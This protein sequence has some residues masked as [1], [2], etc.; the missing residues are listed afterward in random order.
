M[1][2]GFLG[3]VVLMLLHGPIYAKDRTGGVSGDVIDEQGKALESVNVVLLKTA[4]NTLVKASLTDNKGIFRIES[5]DAGRYVLKATLIGFQTFTDTI[6]IEGTVRKLPS[7]R[8]SKKSAALDEVTVRTQKPFMEVK[9]DKI[10]VNVENSIVS[11]G[12]TVMEVLQRSP[13]ITVDQN[14]RISMK[15]KQ[16]VTIMMDGK[17]VPVAGDNLA[18]LLKNMPSSTVEKIELI[19]N[20]GAKYDAAGTGGIINI[21]TKKDKRMGFNGSAT[22]SFGQGVY[23]RTNDALNLNYKSKKI[24][25]YVNYGFVTRTGFNG[26]ILDRKFLDPQTGKVDTEYKQANNLLLPMRYHNIMAGVDYNLSSKTTLGVA[27]TGTRTRYEPSGTSFSDVYDRNGVKQSEFITVNDSKNRLNDYSFNLNFKHDFDTSGTE[28]TADADYATYRYNTNQHFINAFFDTTDAPTRQNYD[29]LGSPT[30]ATTIR[31]FKTDFTHP[32]K[33]SMRFEA[34][35]KLSYVTAGDNSQYSIKDTITDVYKYDSSKSNNFIYNEN[36]NAAYVNLAQDRPKWSY[37]FGLRAEQTVA[38]GEQKVY[39]VS[40][41]NRNYIQLFPSLATQWHISQQHDLGLTLSRR[42]DRPNYEQLNPFKFFL[43]PSNYKVGNPDLQPSL[44]YAVEL[45][46][47]YKQK[48]VTTL[49]CSIINDVITEVIQP[50]ETQKNESIQTNKNLKRQT[51][52][53]LSVAYPFQIFK[54][55]SNMTTGNVYYSYFDGDIAGT[56][57]HNGKPA[58]D[59]N[60]TNNFLLPKDF[61]AELSLFYQSGMLYGYMTL[62]PLWSL[63]AG[64]QK[65]LFQKRA[66]V[67]LAFTD[68]FWKVNPVGLTSFSNYHE[69]FVVKRDTRSGVISFT[70][71]FGNRGV[72]QVRK[73]SGGAEDEK[74]R[75]ASSAG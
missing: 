65:N 69:T 21:K 54:W 25:A 45:S 40:T 34:G 38:K 61:S 70:Y 20:P 57:L 51:F 32:M 37:Q 48:F 64:V 58:F 55:W 14:D 26:L 16:G 49:S 6:D 68:I 62:K 39:P 15:G 30:G 5:I 46:H 75:A 7:I 33:N 31:S 52:V 11:T 17:P 71:R 53:G 3:L 66:T 23:S 35:L 72:G 73:K 41:F 50:S 56:P 13:G 67:K 1:K 9:A 29:L 28:L 42:I 47:T 44:T 27:A 19:S 59:F 12:S 63:N 10:I 2:N 43:D 60:T 18:N 4:G 24:S 36:I 22:G 74:R 8:L